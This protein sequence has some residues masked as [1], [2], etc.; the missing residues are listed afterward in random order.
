MSSACKCLTD[1]GHYN[2]PSQQAT[3]WSGV[4]AAQ[5]PEPGN[6]LSSHS[7][8]GQHSGDQLGHGRKGS[9]SGLPRDMVYQMQSQIFFCTS[10]NLLWGR[11]GGRRGKILLPSYHPSLSISFFPLLSLSLSLSKVEQKKSKNI[12]SPFSLFP[13]QSCVMKKYS[14][15]S[16]QSLHIN[17]R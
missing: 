6:S 9:A 4:P 14:Y 2:C 10:H 8:R 17:G 12:F 15:T 7:R 11:G 13:L 3:L 5:T 16:S 1:H